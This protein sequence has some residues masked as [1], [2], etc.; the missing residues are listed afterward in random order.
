[1]LSGGM[2]SVDLGNEGTAAKTLINLYGGVTP[3]PLVGVGSYGGI[4]GSNAQVP[5]SGQ[6]TSVYGSATG[7]GTGLYGLINQIV[8]TINSSGGTNLGAAITAAHNEVNSAR[9]VSSHAKVIIF[10]S[11]GKPNLPSGNVDKAGL[12]LGAADT[13]KLA[14]DQVFSIHFGTSTGRDLVA[15]LASGTVTN[16]PHQPGSHNNVTSANSQAQ[17]NA[18]NADGD[19]FFIAP[20]S[21]DMAS[22]FS[23]IA[24]IVCP[25]IATPPPPPPTHAHVI[26]I[27][28]VNNN[29]SGTLTASN[30]TI[31]VSAVNPSVSSFTGLSSPGKNIVN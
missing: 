11:D 7:S 28:N 16:S 12:S 18:E 21:T 22:I 2:S 8:T 29:N 23:T 26:V 20:A 13:A 31:N 14:G 25:A 4:D 5:T 10:V 30:F 27:T 9:H 24:N 1:M 3:H 17:I 19:N 15:S 6:L